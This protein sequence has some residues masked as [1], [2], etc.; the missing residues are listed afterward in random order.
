M[1]AVTYR[2]LLESAALVTCATLDAMRDEIEVFR[3]IN[4]DDY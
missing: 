4:H 1:I 2:F 3:C